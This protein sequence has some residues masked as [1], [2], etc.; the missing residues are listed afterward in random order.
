MRE[1][2]KRHGRNPDAITIS[3]LLFT[4]TITDSPAATRKTAEM[5]APMFGVTPELMLQSPLSL[6]GT[7]EECVT[8]LR[9]RARNWGVSQFI[10]SGG[11]GQDLAQLR[12]IR[13]KIVAHI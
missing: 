13:E 3:N 6:I 12:M 7:P 8:E 5:M 9:R 4:V 11:I 10:F 1:E 2:A